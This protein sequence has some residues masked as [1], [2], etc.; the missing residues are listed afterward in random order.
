MSI[1]SQGC[2]P[3][4]RGSLHLTCT[5]PQG[6]SSAKGTALRGR[7]DAD[8]VVFISRFKRFSDQGTLRAEVITEIHAQLQA[9]Q[10]TKQFEVAFEIPK[11]DNPRVLSF[12]LTS[13]TLLDHS[14]DFDVLPAFDALGEGPGCGA[15]CHCSPFLQRGQRKGPFS[16][17]PTGVV[18]VSCPQTP[19][20][21]QVHHDYDLEP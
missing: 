18:P 10:K 14:V 17:D 8:L 20:Q 13:R 12:S 1:D 15:H 9:C 2:P 4:L 7:S 16:L 6:G 5:P 3:V 19:W 21:F 11:W